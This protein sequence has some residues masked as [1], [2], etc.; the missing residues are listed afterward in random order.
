MVKKH[1]SIVLYYIN[2]SKSFVTICANFH[3]RWRGCVGIEERTPE[4]M[5][6]IYE[7]HEI[8]HLASKTTN[9]SIYLSIYVSARYFVYR[10]SALFC[11]RESK[12]H[13][14]WNTF[15]FLI[16]ENLC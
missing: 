7:I 1:S 2:N 4:L 13:D 8:G 3:I 12:R 6:C 14:N 5:D 10:V 9:L 16:N 11:K 15:F